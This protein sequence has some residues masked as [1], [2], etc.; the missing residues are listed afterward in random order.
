MTDNSFTS[1]LEGVMNEDIAVFVY[2]CSAILVAVSDKE[3]Q[4]FISKIHQRKGENKIEF[5][6]FIK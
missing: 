6:N 2:V 3:K 5:S 1:V 4:L